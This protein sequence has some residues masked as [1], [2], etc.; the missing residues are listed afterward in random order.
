MT[1]NKNMEKQYFEESDLSNIYLEDSWVNAIYESDSNL[2]FDLNAILTEK[3][4]LFSLPKPGEMF[5]HKRA[6]LTFVNVENIKWERIRMVANIDV[7]G[8]VDFGNI[9][10]LTISDSN[11][12]LISGDWGFVTFKAKSFTFNFIE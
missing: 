1:L 8:K 11:E 12:Y 6:R 10:K 2:I 9:D 5:C 3:H 4:Y 7:H